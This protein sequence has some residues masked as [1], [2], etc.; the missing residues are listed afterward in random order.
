MCELLPVLFKQ[1]IMMRLTDVREYSF[2][3]QTSFLMGMFICQLM[4]YLKILSDSL[5]VFRVWIKYE[6]GH[7]IGLILFS[8]V[9]LFFYTEQHLN[10]VSL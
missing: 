4:L 10:L 2:L 5:T 1:L 7:G 8:S 9:W 3:Y 6:G